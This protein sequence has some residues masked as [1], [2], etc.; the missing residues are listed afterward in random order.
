MARQPIREP[1]ADKL[2][3]VALGTDAS[4]GN[5][6]EYGGDDNRQYHNHFYLSTRGIMVVIV[7]VTVAVGCLLTYW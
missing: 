4:H 1:Q 7:A 5:F 6:S 3:D 2:L